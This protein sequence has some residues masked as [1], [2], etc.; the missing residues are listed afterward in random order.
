M[1][2][3]SVFLAILALSTGALAQNAPSYKFKKPVA[4]LPVQTS[5]GGPSN[6]DSGGGT[7]P[8]VLTGQLEVST[9]ALNFGAVEVGNSS[10]L[11]FLVGNFGQAA[12]SLNP[13]TYLGLGYTADSLCGSSLNVAQDCQVSV[14]FSPTA[15]GAF[16]GSATVTSSAGSKT[17]T[18]TG[19][20]VQASGSLQPGTSADFGSVVVGQSADRVFLFSNTGDAP[21]R[22]TQVQAVSAPLS[23]VS[24]SCGNVVSP[25]TLNPGQNCSVSLRYQPTAP[26]ALSSSLTVVSSAEN[27]PVSL[28]LVG[29]ALQG[30]LLLAPTDE[31]I[32]FGFIA[33]GQLE[34]RS[35]TLSNTGNAPLSNINIAVSSHPDIA[36]TQNNCGASLAASNSCEFSITYQPSE[37]S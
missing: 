34:T 2:K 10:S 8:P 5:S 9:N 25:V 4:Q 12:L 18:F 15:R 30:I 21:A 7:P 33:Q 37:P 11:S 6:P 20:G 17:V 23:I 24:N 27:S 13:V 29:Q 19:Q 14:S 32:D 35:F 3:T 1:K 31:T 26:T 36:I 22:N 28:N 16:N